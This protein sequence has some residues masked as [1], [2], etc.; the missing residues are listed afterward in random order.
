MTDEKPLAFHDTLYETLYEEIRR[1]AFRLTSNYETAE[2]IVQET[3]L[4]IEQTSQKG[5]TLHNPR[6]WAYRTARNLAI[7]HY[8]HQG[9]VRAHQNGEEQIG[10]IP[11]EALRFNPVLLAEKKER[12]DMM[13]EKLNEL[14]A[15]HREM[16]RLKFQE[17]LKYAE[18]AEVLDLPVTTVA[19]RL[20][21]AIATLRKKLQ[22]TQL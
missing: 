13:H 16:L 18:I 7:D 1:Y 22:T 4:R 9:K 2:E 10:E 11:A 8:R 14:P 21:E 17:N 20:H 5:Q 12:I 3:F 15:S 6:V 19:W